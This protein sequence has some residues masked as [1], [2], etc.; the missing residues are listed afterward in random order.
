ME[1]ETCGQRLSPFDG[2]ALGAADLQREQDFHRAARQRLARALGGEGVVEGLGLSLDVDSRSRGRVTLKVQPGVALAADGEVLWLRQTHPLAIDPPAM[3]GDYGVWLVRQERPDLS[4]SRPVLDGEAE[5]TA[6][7]CEV[8]TLAVLPAGATQAT[9]ALLGWLRSRLGALVVLG[10]PVP[11]AGREDWLAESAWR[12]LVT[13][14]LGATQAVLDALERTRT[15]AEAP[16]A[17]WRLTAVVCAVESMLLRPGTSDVVLARQA[18]QLVLSAHRFVEGLPRRPDALEEV[19]DALAAL[20]SD[21][22]D[23]ATAVP[24]AIPWMERLQGLVP[25][26]EDVAHALT[27]TAEGRASC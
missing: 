11:R 8:L 7:V 10:R 4:S 18:G 1:L 22:P 2:M 9:G 27:R 5:R 14:L 15:L 19:V 16:L 23:A 26:W 13:R 6:A 21:A 24:T 12:P 17:G 20:A 3:D 25:R